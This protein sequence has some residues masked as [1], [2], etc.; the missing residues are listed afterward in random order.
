MA[1]LA[2]CHDRY[3]TFIHRAAD[4]LRLTD[5][6]II[7]AVIAETLGTL[8]LV[9][10]GDS[11]GAQKF[12]SKDK[13][14]QFLAVSL[15]W[16]AAVTVGVIVSGKAG[17]AN[18]NPAIAV[19][20]TITGRSRWSL[21]PAFVLAE[22]AGAYLAAGLI[23]AAYHT[24][25][26][27]YTMVNDS[28]I[29]LVNTTGGI[30]VANKGA[31]LQSAVTD[32]IITTAFLAFGIYA[33]IDNKLVEKPAHFTPAAVGLI[34]FLAIGT[35]TANASSALNPARDLGPRLLLLSTYWGP[36]AFQI[37]NYYFWVPL[38]MPT[39]GAVVG[40]ILYELLIGIHTDEAAPYPD[41]PKES[42]DELSIY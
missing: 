26:Y 36:T 1:P 23:L 34:V 22:I 18:L 27:H 32:Q 28:G 16:G 2:N 29:Y 39:V 38:F 10:Y 3:Q 5:H 33:I 14:N 7:R 41:E 21:L 31:S 9:F 37:D 42:I 17:P 25:I 35:Y 4:K 24:N 13:A 20:N 12:S 15:G 19:A 30:F 11:A 6:K 8:L 40:A